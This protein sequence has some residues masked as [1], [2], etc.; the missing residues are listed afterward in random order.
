MFKPAKVPN[1]VVLIY[2]G[3]ARFDQASE[4]E[5]IEGLVEACEAVGRAIQASSTAAC[6]TKSG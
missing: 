6:R 1:W 3:Q 5:M 2:E 4:T